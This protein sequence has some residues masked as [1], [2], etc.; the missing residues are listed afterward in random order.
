M[1]AHDFS[2]FD[3]E[4]YD[5]EYEHAYELEDELREY[6]TEV[7]ENEGSGLVLDYAMAFLDDVDFKEIA[8][9]M[10]RDALM[11]EGTSC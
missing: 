8:I 4:K 5:N 9:S 3:L 1:S 2:G 7:L 6:V 11:D 10:V